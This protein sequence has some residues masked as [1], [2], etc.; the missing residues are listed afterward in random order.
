MAGWRNHEAVTRVTVVLTTGALGF[1]EN[2]WVFEITGYFFW[3]VNRF[4]DECPFF[5]EG[6]FKHYGLAA[7]S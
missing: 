5:L 6:G 1:W 2:P 4:C 3:L 7:T